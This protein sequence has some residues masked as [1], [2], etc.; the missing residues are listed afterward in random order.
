MDKHLNSHQVIRT[1]DIFEVVLLSVGHFDW[2]DHCLL[3]EVFVLHFPLESS[4]LFHFV[5]LL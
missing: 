1:L 5:F 3:L 4:V 2:R